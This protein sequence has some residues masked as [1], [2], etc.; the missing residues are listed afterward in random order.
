MPSS[1]VPDTLFCW[2]FSILF[3]GSLKLYSDA[4]SCN[5]EKA[6]KPMQISFGEEH[7]VA[8]MLL[9]EV[10]WFCFYCAN[11]K[12]YCYCYNYYCCY[13]IYDLLTDGLAWLLLSLSSLSSLL[14]SLSS[15]SSVVLISI[16]TS[17]LSLLLL[18]LLLVSCNYVT[19][20]LFRAGDVD[21]DAFYV[22][23]SG[24]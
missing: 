11:D 21:N 14:L 3:Y 13:L 2:S 4:N 12:S 20:K 1:F 23:F 22:S 16:L 18:L 24:A 17:F 6:K 8:N 15:S 19:S 7:K 10:I 5:L 9:G